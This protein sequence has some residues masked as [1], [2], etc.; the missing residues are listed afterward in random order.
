MR[1]QTVSL[2]DG[3]SERP[4]S[5][6][7]GAP[8]SAAAP[9]LAPGRIPALDGLRAVAVLLVLFSH[10]T[11]TKG[12]PSL[13]WA[14]AIDRLGSAG[15]DVFFVLSGFLI[16]SL[17]CRE[18]D[19]SRTIS[20]PA[21]YVRRVLRL[22]PAYLCFL[23]FVAILAATGKADIA[24]GDWIAAGTYTM[25][26]RAHPAWELGHIWS[27]SIEEHFYLL[28]PPMLALLPRRGAIGGLSAV[29]L[30]EPLVRLAVLVWSPSHAS[31]SELWTFTRLDP[32]AA[33]CLLALV[34]RT[35]SGVRSLGAAARAWPAVLA[36][37]VAAM[38]GSMISGKFDVGVGPSLIAVT[39]AL[40]VWAA[41]HHEPRWLQSPAMIAIGLGSYSLYL[42]QEVF[43]NPRRFEWWNQFPQNLLLAALFAV[44]S[45][46]VIERPFL[47]VKARRASA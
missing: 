28:W 36:L 40:L 13:G 10:A 1:G 46:R 4:S 33:G 23:G 9:W 20:L 21:F 16:T 2:D 8:A 44:L 30:L 6:R 27:L 29:L 11:L 26:F 32:L 14:S 3:S 17:L 39:L 35:A 43:L 45:Y 7:S 38:I 12:F 19:R 47:R 41:I 34:S 24:R 42:W 15:V 22:L 31:E 25:N 18:R 5:G 37:L